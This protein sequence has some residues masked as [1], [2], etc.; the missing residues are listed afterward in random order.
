MI[1]PYTIVGVL[2]DQIEGKV[3]GDVQP[4]ILLPQQ[5][6]PIRPLFYPALLKTLVS[7]VVKTRGDIPVAAEM[8]S[9]FHQ[10]APGFALDDFQSMQEAI[11]RNTFS[12]RLGLYLVGSFAGLAVALVF[13]GLYGVISQL[14]GY[15]RHEIGVRV[16]LGATRRSV[17]Q[18]ILRQGSTLIGSG[19]S[20]PYPGSRNGTLCERF[21]IS[22]TTAGWTDLWSGCHRFGVHRAH[23]IHSSCAQ[24]GVD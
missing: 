19:C 1:K 16:A 15:R 17:A 8:R 7:F 11:E 10:A 5:Q 3:G 20:R 12:Q 22:S 23:C 13:I 4:L 6:I 14:V 18:L 9:V 21:L 2:V 24:S